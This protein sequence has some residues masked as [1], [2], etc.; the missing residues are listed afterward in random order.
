[1]AA[2]SERVP[3]TAELGQD[4][5]RRIVVGTS[6]FG[7][8][9]GSGGAGTPFGPAAAPTT[10]SNRHSS[11]NR[12]SN[13]LV[14]PPGRQLLSGQ[15]TRAPERQL[16]RCHPTLPGADLGANREADHAIGVAGSEGRA[17]ERQPLGPKASGTKETLPDEG[18]QIRRLR[19]ARPAVITS[20]ADAAM[21][22]AASCAGSGGGSRGRCGADG[23]DAAGARSRVGAPE[24]GPCRNAHRG[25]HLGST[26]PRSGRRRR[27]PDPGFRR[28]QDQGHQGWRGR[29]NS[30]P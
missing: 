28:D 11:A 19:L 29:S 20:S 26:R 18:C 8:R 23:Y 15:D 24:L 30:V 17:C 6:R 7:H 21:A 1:M 10:A 2:G 22:T 12:S 25:P 3:L 27:S 5:A 9:H 4:Q 16:P 14:A 13:P